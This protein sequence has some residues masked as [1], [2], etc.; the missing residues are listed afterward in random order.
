MFLETPGDADVPK[1]NVRGGGRAGAAPVVVAGER[2]E[3]GGVVEEGWL[4]RAAGAA[5]EGTAEARGG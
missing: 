3:V 5:V 1:L 2:V 4:A